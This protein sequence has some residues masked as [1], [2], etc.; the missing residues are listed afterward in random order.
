[1]NLLHSCEITWN[2]YILETKNRKTYLDVGQTSNNSIGQQCF[3]CQRYGH[4]KSDYPTFLRSKGKAMIVTFSNDEVFDNE[5]GSDKDGNF[6]TFTAITVIDESVAVE[7]N[8]SD[9][10]LSKDT[11]LQEAYNKL[12]KVAAKDAMNVDL[13]LQKIASLELDKKICS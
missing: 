13:G 6:I 2:I 9:W 8:P 5:S 3:G 12:C 1:M 4:V 10:E 11:N 7:E